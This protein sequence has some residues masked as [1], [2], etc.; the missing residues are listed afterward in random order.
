MNHTFIELLRNI[1][2]NLEKEKHWEKSKLRY[3]LREVLK[4]PP[5]KRGKESTY[6]ELTLNKL[7]FISKLMDSNLSPSIRQLKEILAGVND[8]EVTRVAQ[9]T[10]RLEIGMTDIDA[11]GVA[12]HRTLSG[13][14]WS[15]SDPRMGRVMQ[16]S[17]RMADV[18]ESATDYVAREFSKHLSAGA[19]APRAPKTAWKEMNFGPDLQIRYRKSLTR[20][21]KKQLH[22]AGELMRSIVSR[23]D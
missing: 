6:P 15:Q 11:T 5:Q 1:N 13:E 8:D 14:A 23:E 17:L 21:Q 20:G 10:E 3:Y 4:E 16:T 9:G 19:P 2:A 12:S 22:L 18:G 7:L